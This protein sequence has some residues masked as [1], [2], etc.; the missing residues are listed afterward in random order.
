MRTKLMLLGIVLIALLLRLWNLDGLPYGF[1]PDEASFG[2]DAYSI[3]TTGKDQW[4]HLMPITLESFGDFK[5]P[6]YSYISIPFIK[7]LGLT[8]FAVRLPNSIFGTLAV[9]VTFFL[10]KELFKEHIKSNPKYRYLPLLASSLLAI[11]PWHIMLS[12]GAFE[13]NLTTLIIPLASY[14]FLRGLSDK[15]CLTLSSVLFGLNLFSYHS[16]RLVT[17]LIVLAL[18][19]FNFKKLKETNCRSM[20]IAN[21]V[22]IAIF[23]F[24]LGLSF[25]SLLIGGGRRAQDISIFSGALEEASGERF[26]AQYQGVEK[27]VARIFNN[28]YQIIAKRFLNNYS[29]YFSYKFLFSDGPAEGTYGMI[30]G[31]GVIYLFEL[32]FIML[33]I[34]AAIKSNKKTPYLFL[35][36]WVLLSP[37]PASLTTGRGFAAN[38]VDVIFPALSIISAIGA[39]EMYLWFK[40]SIPNLFFKIFF[41]LYIFLSLTLIFSFGT[42]Y[43]I[44]SPIK[45]AKSMLYGNLE[46]ANWLVAN[47]ARYDKIIVSKSLSEPYIYIAFASKWNAALYQENTRKWDIYKEQNK[48][49]LDQL[50]RYSLGK[51]EFQ[52]LNG[53]GDIQSFNY[54]LVGRPDD[55]S[56]RK[57]PVAKFLY[58]D[59]QVAVIAVETLEK[60]YAQKNY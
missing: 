20:I 8:K 16:A 18:V 1:T 40:S 39:Y 44:V 21:W 14:F 19:F 24:F 53:L 30:P 5:M 4:G 59:G 49:F 12:R 7:L 22:P 32:P 34:Y 60:A 35:V 15:R 47:S 26:L 29:Q 17:P 10:T 28:K 45:S 56:V 38:R 6:L 36:L 23:S 50:E 31:R 27:N 55:F 48:S 33:F 43:Y 37:I 2:Y 13:A 25:Y 42:D 9:L 46:M 3:L 41:Y 54:L 52:S 51:Y 57:E 11:S 58:P